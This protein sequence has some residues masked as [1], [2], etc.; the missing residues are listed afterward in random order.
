MR[1]PKD[2]KF[3][4]DAR[5]AILSGVNVLADAV[6][7]TLG[8]K[9]RNVVIERAMG[10]PTITKDGVTVARDIFLEDRFENMGA[11]MV[12]EVASKTNDV[13]GDGTTTATVLAQCIYREGAKLVAAGIN[14][15]EIKRGIDT[16]VSRVVDALSR[17]SKQIKDNTEIAQV[18]TISAN[19]D[20]EIGKIIAE[21]MDKVGKEGIIT[22]EDSPSMDTTL[23]TVDGMQFDRGAISPYFVTDLSRMEA[24]LDDAHIL[25]LE[26]KLLSSKDIMAVLQLVAERN[27]T[28]LVIAES[29]EGE[30]LQTLVVN[31]VKGVLRCSAVKAPEF[32]ARRKEMLQDIAILTGGQVITEDQGMKLEN[33]TL[34]MLGK[35]G[36][37]TMTKDSTTI[38]NGGG[39]KKALQTR[40]KQIRK[41]IKDSKSDYDKEKLQ[42]RL[43]KLIGG[44][45]II[46][47]GAATET[48]LREKKMRVEDALAATRAAVE[49]G[50]VPGGG[51]AYLR[52]QSSLD[53]L[54]LSGDQQAGVDIVR[55]TL[56]E[57]LRQIVANA[58]LEGSIIVDKV[59]KEKGPFGFDARDETYTDLIK[60][61]VID[62]TKV[63]RCALQN[64][65]SV[66][67]LM[68]TTEA[69]IADK[70]PKD[71]VN[72]PANPP[73]GPMPMM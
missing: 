65:A 43:A 67:S 8:P 14:P 32:G 53:K 27:K 24:V 17:I 72:G 23:E 48:E 66:A 62:P 46:N 49:E 35:A 1:N 6:K 52:A 13:A 71:G 60:A 34:D 16:A 7:V 4:Q 15:M 31:K 57:P 10:S 47:I 30:A 44:V 58:G 40:A 5:T 3:S 50:I 9:G 45:A 63:T 70:P 38:I 54:K 64:A 18:G 21:A 68:L 59:K 56:E 42:E 33:I 37:V 12:K 11:Q 61:G 22:V 2:L 39:T 41:Q 73:V 19:N 51:V 26:Q 28:I 69:M 55:R 25:M 20:K 36:R 29:V